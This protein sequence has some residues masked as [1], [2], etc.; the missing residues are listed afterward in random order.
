[1]F[2][3]GTFEISMLIIPIVCAIFGYRLAKARN[4]EAGIWAVVCFLLPILVIVLLC[5]G[6]LPE[7]DKIEKS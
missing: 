1:M 5:L 7:K 4:R 3:L 6:P 2:G